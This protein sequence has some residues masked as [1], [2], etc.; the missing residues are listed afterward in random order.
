MDKMLTTS[1]VADWLK[2]RDNFLI[3]THRR[4]D[5]DTA[6][7][8][9]ALSQA[10][11]E[12]GKTAYV[13]Y[14]PEITPRYARYT[15]AYWASDDYTPEHIIIVDT[16]SLDLFPKNADKYKDNIS[17]CIDHHSSNTLYADLV[18]LDGDRATCGE[19]L[20]DILMA[21]SGNISAISAES[22][23]VAVSTDTGC[24]AFGNTTANTLRVASLLIEAG[25][26]HKKINKTLFR[27]KTR[28]R[29]ELEGMLGIRLEYFF[30]GK[31]AIA[32]ITKEMIEKSGA[33]E[34]D[35]DDI[36]ALPGAIEGVCIG[37]TIRELTS[38]YDCKISVRSQSP[39]NSGEICSHFGGGGHKTAAGASSEKP[40]EE[41]KKELLKVLH[42]HM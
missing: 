14:N 32:T 12:Q 41:I 10:L 23:Y 39:Y 28:S 34:D 37:I 16:A 2:E 22:L 11:R 20:F 1:E 40:V 4:P 7:C 18:C 36:A 17:L 15:E 29:I 21:M 26:P 3:I 19:I 33:V 6:G 24:F 30:D 13:L 38:E 31:V 42:N 5:G 9:G 8:A 27:T 35:L 25:A